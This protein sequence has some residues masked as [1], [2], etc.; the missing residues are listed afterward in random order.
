MRISDSK[1]GGTKTSSFG[2]PGRVNHDASDFYNSNLYKG[3]KKSKKG[4]NYLENKI[5]KENLNKIYCKTSELMDEIPDYSVHL[6]VTSPPY[7]ANK[8]YDKDLSLDEYRALLKRVFQETYNKLVTGGRAC[9]NIANLGRKPYIPLHAYIIED[10]YTAG[11]FTFKIS[12]CKTIKRI[13][14]FMQQVCKNF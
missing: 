12:F 9:V 2:T 11:I 14:L 13:P 6:M 3:Q 5:D 1:R 8:E 7:N 10:I 4:L